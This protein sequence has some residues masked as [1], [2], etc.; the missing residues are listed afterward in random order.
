MAFLR[1][2]YRSNSLEMATSF[3]VVLPDDK[4]LK[5]TPVVYLLYCLSH[6][7]TNFER[8]TIL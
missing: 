2:D 7:S 6:N 5:D 1:C 3:C 4:P 8:Y